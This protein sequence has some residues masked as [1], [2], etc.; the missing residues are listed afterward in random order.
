VIAGRP[1]IISVPVGTG[2]V[3]LFGVRVQHRAQTMATY[4]LLFNAIFTSR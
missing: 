4:R 2:R 3:V 1:A